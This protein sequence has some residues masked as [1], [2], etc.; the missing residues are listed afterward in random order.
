ME[1]KLVTSHLPAADFK[2]SFSAWHLCFDDLK[3]RLTSDEVHSISSAELIPREK[4]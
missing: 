1:V 3:I 4:I 2:A